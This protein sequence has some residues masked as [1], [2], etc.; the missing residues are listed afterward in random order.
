MLVYHPAYDAYHCVF[1]L[2]TILEDRKP[3]EIDRIRI[4]DFLLCFPT[5][6]AA[7]RLPQKAAGIRKSAKLADSAY[8]TPLSPKATFSALSAS[9]DGALACLAAASFIATDRL[10]EDVVERTNAP[11]PEHLRQQGA[12]LRERERLFFEQILPALLEIPLL[13]QDGLKARSGL[14]E[15]RYDTLQA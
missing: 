10:R 2:L 13:G 3:L 12:K 1:R 9:Q 4:L 11:L 6:V 5:V 8:R 7:F 15:H 14:L